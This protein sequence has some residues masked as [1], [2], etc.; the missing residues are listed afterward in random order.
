M[1]LEVISLKVGC[2]NKGSI[3]YICG[4]SSIISVLAQSKHRLELLN[5][6]LRKFSDH[7]VIIYL[8]ESSIVASILEDPLLQGMPEQCKK[9]FEFKQHK[10]L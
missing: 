10:T 8:C 2:G 9:A 3:N 5:S 6:Q 7:S 1:A 4:L